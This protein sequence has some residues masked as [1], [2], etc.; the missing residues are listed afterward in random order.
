MIGPNVLKNQYCPIDI[1]YTNIALANLQQQYIHNIA[2]AARIYA[3]N[4]NFF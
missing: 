3:F 4:E 2:W 1:T